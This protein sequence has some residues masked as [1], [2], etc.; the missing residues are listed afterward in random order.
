M[1]QREAIKIWNEYNDQN[2][3]ML[4]K[5]G[6]LTMKKRMKLYLF[7]NSKKVEFHKI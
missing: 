2:L 3:Q 1:G 6:T 4:Q 5:L 7:D